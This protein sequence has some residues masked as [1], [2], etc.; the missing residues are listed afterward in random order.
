MAADGEAEEDTV[1]GAFVFREGPAGELE[2][3]GDFDGLYGA[4]DDPWGQSGSDERL[5]RY[6]DRSRATIIEMLRSLGPVDSLLEVGSGLGQVCAEI[7]DAGCANAVDGVD[8][9]RLAVEKAATRYPDI[10]FF[11]GDIR[12][13]AFAAPRPAYDAVLVN[14]TLWYILDAL[15]Q[16]LDN[17]HRVLAEGGH[18]LIANAFMRTP[19]RYGREVIDGFDG[20]VRYLAGHTEGLFLFCDARLHSDPEL[21]YDDGHVLMRKA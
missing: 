13:P 9:S 16:V 14:Q 11:V 10:H 20:L 7:R 5:G 15:P 17:I 8:S 21:L 19:Q 1:S 18:L 4:E 6:Y 12:D 3:V 2:F